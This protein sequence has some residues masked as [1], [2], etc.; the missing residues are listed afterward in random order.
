MLCFLP[1]DTKNCCLPQLQS[2]KPHRKIVDND[3]NGLTSA[4]EE[5]SVKYWTLCIQ[6]QLPAT[7]SVT[8]IFLWYKKAHTHCLTTHFPPKWKPT[9]LLYSTSPRSLQRPED[10]P[11][12][13]SDPAWVIYETL[14]TADP[15]RPRC[16][17]PPCCSNE[18]EVEPAAPPTQLA[19][20]RN[21]MR[22]CWN[23]QG[24]PMSNMEVQQNGL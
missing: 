13:P 16:S 15:H 17:P 24:A 23:P 14:H 22:E 7:S 1:H 2:R 9:L 12:K 8:H 5:T 11:H 6:L 3:R 21:I 20:S 10:P 18:V 19:T 4:V